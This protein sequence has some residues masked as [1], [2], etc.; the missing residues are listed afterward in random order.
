MSYTADDAKVSNQLP[1]WRVETAEKQCILLP[2]SIPSFTYT[3]IFLVKQSGKILIK[4][5]K[6]VI[7]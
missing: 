5:R 6:L 2:N 1:V 3:I 4:Y 7:F